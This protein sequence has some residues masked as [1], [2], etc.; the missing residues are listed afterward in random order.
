MSE[1]WIQEIVEKCGVAHKVAI[2]LPEGLKKKAPEIEAALEGKEVIFLADFCWG[3]CDLRDHEAKVLGCDL[4]V[5]V[6]HSPMK[7]ETEVPTVYI[8]FKSSLDIEKV[9][10]KAEEKLLHEEIGLVTTVQHVHELQRMKEILERN[11]KKVFIGKSKGRALHEG[12]VLGCDFGAATSIADKVE[13]FLF[14]GTGNFHPI[15]IS[16]ATDKPVFI[17]DPEK[18]ELREVD[19]IKEKFLRKRFAKIEAAKKAETFGILVSL[20]PGQKKVKEAE[21]AKSLLEKHGKRAYILAT[22]E[23][24]PEKLMGFRLDCYVN[25]ACPRIAI[26]DASRYDK[27]IITPI[28]LEV[29]LG[30]RSWDDYE[31]EYS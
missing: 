17:A 12:Q 13:C 5:H 26:D 19:E 30:E 6:G 31:I 22:N 21:V 29:V 3:A 23:I 24:S 15:G 7:I 4:M 9:V 14:V 2:Q 18:N 10:K 20:K 16:M 8:E 27:P 25:T 1:Y 11:E 28:E